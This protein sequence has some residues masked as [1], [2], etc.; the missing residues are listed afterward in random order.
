MAGA[1]SIFVELMVKTE[2]VNGIN[3]HLIFQTQ[4]LNS[5]FFFACLVVKIQIPL[6]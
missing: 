5:E 1:K 2:W 4:H 6:V 3:S